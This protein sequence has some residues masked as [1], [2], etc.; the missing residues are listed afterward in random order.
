MPYPRA[1][2]LFWCKECEGT[3]RSFT[4]ERDKAWLQDDG[5]RLS[6][7]ATLPG[8]LLPSG[9]MHTVPEDSWIAK[10]VERATCR[11]RSRPDGEQWIPAFGDQRIVISPSPKMM[12]P[13]PMARTSRLLS[14]PFGS[15]MALSTMVAIPNTITDP[16][17]IPNTPVLLTMASKVTHK[18]I[19]MPGPAIRSSLRCLRIPRPQKKMAAAS[20]SV[21]RTRAATSKNLL[22]IGSPTTQG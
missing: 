5:V 2:V 11:S 9:V 6:L 7:L 21:R 13:A 17:T 20:T 19:R 14:I 12:Q 3:E 22:P 18:A 15:A 16:P 4:R 10:S 8:S 1:A